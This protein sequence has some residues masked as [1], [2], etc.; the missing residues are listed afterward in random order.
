MA[1]S[2]RGG[3]GEDRGSH[4]KVTRHF[5][6]VASHN[7][8]SSHRHEDEEEPSWRTDRRDDDDYVLPSHRTVH[9]TNKGNNDHDETETAWNNPATLSTA[10]H[11]DHHWGFATE[12]QRSAVALAPTTVPYPAARTT[13][14][15]VPGI[16]VDLDASSTSEEGGGDDRR[17]PR[18]HRQ[19]QHHITASA[20]SGSSTNSQTKLGSIHRP[21]PV[22]FLLEEREQDLLGK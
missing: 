19:H 8:S 12:D 22:D 20:S 17:E 21:I 6:N 1:E 15:V 11:H 2:R 14:L 5:V 4:H 9:R 13:P 7:T 10:N 16:P 18:H 3:A